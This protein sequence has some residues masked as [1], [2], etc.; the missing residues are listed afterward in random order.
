MDAYLSTLLASLATWRATHMFHAER[1]PARVFE[2]LREAAGRSVVGQ[3]M[4]CYYCLSLWFSAPL[5][6][7]LSPDW[8]ERLLLWLGLS[9]AAIGLEHLSSHWAEPAAASYFEDSLL[10]SPRDDWPT[11]DLPQGATPVDH[12]R[13]H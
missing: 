4:D 12:G 7:L 6:L 13:H 3:A 11:V 1:G 10:A 9:A 2:R 5:A 8:V